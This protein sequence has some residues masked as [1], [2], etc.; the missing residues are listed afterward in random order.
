MYG[1]EC[2]A[3]RLS[4]LWNS[5]SMEGTRW[6]VPWGLYLKASG[7]SEQCPHQSPQRL[8]DWWAYTTQMPFATSMVWPS[9]PGV[10]RRAR[11]REQLLT[12]CRQC[13][14]GSAWCATNV[15]TTHQPYQTLSTATASRT[16]YPQER[17]SLMSQLHQSKHQQG[18]GRINLY[19]LGTWMEESRGTGFPQAALLGTPPTHWH[20]P[21]GDPD[22]EGATHQPTT[23]HHLFSHT[24]WPGSCPLLMNYAR[25]LPAVLDFISLRLH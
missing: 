6:A 15:M 3:P 24:S 20:S 7:Y 16:V 22:G 10:G 1:Q 11:T 8:W 21:G 5:G 9:A 2:L 13:T 4:H 18:T 14:T 17:K 25:H 23:S 12:T 19:S